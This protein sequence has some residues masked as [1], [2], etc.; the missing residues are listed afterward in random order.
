M[1][2]LKTGSGS[3]S[4]GVLCVLTDLE[5]DPL[6]MVVDAPHS[7]SMLEARSSGLGEGMYAPLVGG[8]GRRALG[9]CLSR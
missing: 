7:T 9:Q 5:D 6:F 8:G 1:S 3:C 4:C 2:P